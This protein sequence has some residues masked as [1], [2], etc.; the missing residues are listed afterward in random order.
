[1][2]AKGKR[3]QSRL[4][5]ELIFLHFNL[6][7]RQLNLFR[8]FLPFSLEGGST[9][10]LVLRVDDT[11]NL[12]HNFLLTYDDLFA[13]AFLSELAI[14]KLDP[15]YLAPALALKREPPIRACFPLH[16]CHLKEKGQQP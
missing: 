3:P 8:P 12:I 10:E 13:V 6:D 16:V 5:A 1:M 15:L 11:L 9:V 4:F 7:F 14:G 2:I